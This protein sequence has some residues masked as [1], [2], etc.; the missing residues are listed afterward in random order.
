MKRL[1]PTLTAAV[2]A[3]CPIFGPYTAQA[4]APPP[5]AFVA[6]EGPTDWLAGIFIGEVVHNTAGETVGNINDIVIDR[7]GHII[8][9]V[10]GV[11]GFLGIGEKDVGISYASLA[12]DVGSKGERVI[13][14]DVGKAALLA[15]EPFKTTEKTTMERVKDKASDLG[16]K[17]MD[18]AVDLTNQAAEKI[19]AMKNG[20]TKKQ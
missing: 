6:Q 12:F 5:V 20:D 2:L 9:V 10:L 4:A 1:L 18:K 14:V 15:A 19:E 17:T 3:A 16:T 7:Q 11:G 8:A 13:V